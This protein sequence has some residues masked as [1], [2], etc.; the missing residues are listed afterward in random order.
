MPSRS[1]SLPARRTRRRYAI[2]LLVVVAAAAGWTA[3]G[4]TRLAGPRRNRRVAR[5]A[6]RRPAVSSHA[7]MKASPAIPSASR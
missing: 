6:K 2:L 3:C 5:A 7:A 4:S 1:I